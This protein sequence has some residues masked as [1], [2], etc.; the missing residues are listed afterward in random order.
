MAKGEGYD[1]EDRKALLELVARV[2]GGL[3]PRYRALAESGRIEI[4]STPH[5]HPIAPLLIDFQSA[6]EAW[7]EAVLPRTHH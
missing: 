7:P 6:R 3:I 5:T 1:F 4:S 2:I